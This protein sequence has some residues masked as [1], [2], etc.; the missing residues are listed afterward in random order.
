MRQLFKE[1]ILDFQDHDLDAGVLRLIDI[2]HLTGKA[3][4]CVGV[5]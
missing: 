2:T 1:I 5:R 3:T 4:V